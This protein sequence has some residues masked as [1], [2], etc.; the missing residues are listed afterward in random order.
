MT[1]I[2]FTRMKA[3]VIVPTFI[4]FI[5][6]ALSIFFLKKGTWLHALENS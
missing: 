4:V 3:Q 2:Y 5:V 6:K 1:A